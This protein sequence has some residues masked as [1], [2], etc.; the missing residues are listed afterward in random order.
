MGIF[1]VDSWTEQ[2]NR[3]ADWF[4]THNGFWVLALLL[5][6]LPFVFWLGRR[7]RLF[8]THRLSSQQGLIAGKVVVYLGV[9]LIAVT[10]LQSF[11][12]HIESLLG[13]AGIAGIALGFA[14]QTS[15]SNLISGVFLVAERPFAV[16][17]IIVVGATTGEVLS[18]DALSIKL[19]TFDNRFVRIPNESIIKNE[20][21]NVT[22][23]PI[24]RIDLAIGIAY[25]EDIQKARQVLREVATSEPKCL[26]EPEPLIVVRGFGAS[27]V[28]ILFAPWAAK[29]DFLKTK[30]ALLERVKARFDA[31]G[32]EI[33]FPH[34]S[35]YSG[36]AT[37]PFPV[38]LMHR[39]KESGKA[40]A[41]PG[42]G[43]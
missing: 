31:E 28:D 36:E 1:T 16:G 20:V 3:F 41:V 35:L 32:I 5:L 29:E 40:E 7:V 21:I 24:R 25:K 13:A 11:G 17:D 15:V 33:P 18:V 6:G 4:T 2:Y 8:F 22:R 9:G 43:A 30:D 14:A 37:Q 26:Q 42:S 27:S 23:F 34:V 39:Q 12:F 38:E 19:R 10:A